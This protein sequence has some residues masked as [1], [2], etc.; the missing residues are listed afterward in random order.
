MQL[1]TGRPGLRKLRILLAGIVLAGIA[2]AGFFYTSA[3]RDASPPRLRIGVLPD[4]SPETLQQRYAPLLGYLARQTGIETRLVIPADYRHAVDLFGAD[5]L[6]LVFFGGLT[7]VQARAAHGAEALVM[8][9][10][11]T[12]FT[13][14]FVVRP[15]L[16]QKRLSD[17]K[18]QSLT[19][20]DQLSTSGHLMPRY[21]LEREWNLKPETYFSEIGYSGAHD[22][23]LYLVR[24]GRFD[25]GAVNAG[26]ARQML[27]DGRIDSNEVHVLWQTPPYPDYVWA[28]QPD[29]T[30]NLKT[31]LRDAFLRLDVDNSDDHAILDRLGAKIFLPA[32]SREFET[33]GDIASKLG[34]I[35]GADR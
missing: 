27:D 33:L 14:W 32:D 9:E 15:E 17:L 19:F 23:T 6:D 22:Q 20:G 16:A 1:G 28:V 18:G 31:K 34:L 35:E 2:V 11:D 25:I 3:S 24:D 7:F 8:R 21:F 13:S 5:E 30:E 12:R 10:I 26:I 4:Q 29:L